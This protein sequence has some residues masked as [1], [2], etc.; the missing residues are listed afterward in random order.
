MGVNTSAMGSSVDRVYTVWVI[1][2]KKQTA[3]NRIANPAAMGR[4]NRLPKEARERVGTGST[5]LAVLRMALSNSKMS[6][7]NTVNTQ[8]MLMRTP[9]ASTNPKS[10]PMRKLMNTSIRS[11]TTVVMPLL[12]MEEK[13]WRNARCIARH[14]S[15]S[16]AL[17]CRYRFIRMME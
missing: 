14:R 7:G 8:I 12:R 6:P 10:R 13:A 15:S 9:F 5:F 11:P 1:L 3:T 17:S 2:C 4:R 16:W